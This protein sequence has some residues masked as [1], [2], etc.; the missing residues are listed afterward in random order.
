MD[1]LPKQIAV[2]PVKTPP[3]HPVGDNTGA[4]KRVCQNELVGHTGDRHAIEALFD[5]KQLFES[6]R[7]RAIAGATRQQQGPVDIE[8]QNLGNH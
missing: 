4:A 5:S 8:Q 3:G 2:A 1:L 7:E 6:S